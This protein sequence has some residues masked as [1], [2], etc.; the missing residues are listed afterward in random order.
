MLKGYFSQTFV[1]L[2][3]G[4]A[5]LDDVECELKQFEIVK[6]TPAQEDWRFSGPGLIVAF[7]P[8]VN[9][10]AA[11]DIVDHPWPDPMGDPKSDSTTFG[12]WTLGFFGSYTYPGGLERAGVHSWSWQPGRTIAQQHRGFIRIR[13]SYVFGADRS[14]PI[15]PKEWDPI[16]ELQFVSRLTLALL[17]M[18]CAICYFNPNGEIL[19]DQGSFRQFWSQAEQQGKL[20]LAL[21]ANIRF[22][23]LNDTL[24]FMDTIGN[25]QLG[26]EDVEVV[27][28]KS[29]YEPGVI[30]Y[31]LRNVT[32]YLREIRGRS[33][34]RTGDE[35][36]GPNETNLSWTE[37]DPIL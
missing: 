15:L 19:R 23:S 3:N 28:P 14:A 33:M 20:P 18:P 21:W 9:G 32:H 26:V 10:Y 30:D 1:V 22:F 5:S 17:N 37:V 35:I 25:G 6:R 27:Y 36:D 16:N 2:T 11:I 24:G 7:R 13:V 12:A 4:E 29:Q 31:Y 8:E 34:I